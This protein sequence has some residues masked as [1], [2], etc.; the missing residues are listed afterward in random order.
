MWWGACDALALPHLLAP[1]PDIARENAPRFTARL[2]GPRPALFEVVIDELCGAATP[3]LLVVEDAH[4]ADDATLDL[5]KYLGRRV[6]R[7]HALLA[8]SFRDDEVGA[9]H[10]L[11][12][13]PGELPPAA[14][15]YLPVPRPSPAAV[16]TLALRTPSSGP[17]PA[18]SACSSAT[19]P[20]ASS[21][22]GAR[23][24]WPVR[25]A[26]RPRWPAPSSIPAPP[27]ICGARPMCRP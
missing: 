23:W 6:G 15:S 10:P 5:L 3:L 25:R 17:S 2:A 26:T 13:V 20:G 14:R 21:R 22:V 12:R 18:T 11:R 9:T 24:P 19:A 7:T 27:A 1:L 16:Q 4:R 8:A